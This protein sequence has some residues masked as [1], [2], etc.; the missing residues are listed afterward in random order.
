M[1]G[2]TILQYQI[3]EKFGEGGMGV[4]Y[5][6]RD[7]KLNRIVA[8][9]VLPPELVSDPGRKARF[10]QEARAAS[11]LNHPNIVTIH[12]IVSQDS[13][14]CI[15]ME[16]V[17]G[18]P[19]AQLIALKE[20]RIPDILKL[21]AQIAD[22]IAAAHT[23]GI[24]HRDLKPS[25]IMV[26]ES[27]LV[28]VLDFGLAKLISGPP[29]PAGATI[30]LPRTDPGMI[31]GT[32]G[33]MSPEQVRGQEL[34]R[35]SDIFNFGLILY[36]MLAGMRAFQGDTSADVAS[37]ILKESPPD[38]P[39]SVP[40][41]LRQIVAI[42][43]EKS[44]INRFES[45]RDIGF[46]LRALSTGTSI[47]GVVP[48][49]EAAAPK[50]RPWKWGS[51]LAWGA[52]AATA[53]VFTALYFLGRPEPLD[54]SAYKYTPFATEA[55]LETGGAWSPDGKSI[56]YLKNPGVRGQLFVRSL[57]SPIPTQ[58]ANDTT[59]I[60]VNPFWSPQGNRVYFIN[61]RKLWSV[62]VAGG[63]PLL[64]LSDVD[65]AAALSPEGNALAFWR[66][67][68]REGKRMSSLWISSPPGSPPRKY[69]PAPFESEGSGNPI[70]IRFAPD[71]AK[72]CLSEV[73]TNSVWLLDWPDGPKA[74]AR[75][76]FPG[77]VFSWAPAFDWMPNSRHLVMAINGELWL[78]D[79][80]TGK[81]RQATSSETGGLN[82]PSVSPDGQRIV[83]TVSND[84]YNIV[85]I[86]LDG[87]APRPYLAT[88]RDERSPS[89][90]LAGDRMAY[91]TKRSG[92]D[93]IWLR[94][95][96]G[97]WERPIVT[98]AD[99]PD[100]TDSAFFLMALSPDGGQVAFS[101]QDREGAKIWIA[102]ASGGKAM[103]AMPGITQWEIAPSFSPDGALFACVVF[104]DR[105]QIAVVRVGSPEPPYYH[106]DPSPSTA[107]I[108]S[109]DGRSI[110]YGSGEELILITPD[111]KITRRIPSP[112]R[113]SNQ[114]FVM[115]WSRDSSVIYMASSQSQMAQ[116]FAVEVNTGKATK[117]ADLGNDIEFSNDVGYSMSGSLSPDGKG[118]FTSDRVRKSDLWILEGFPQ[119]QRRRRR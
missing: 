64:A 1:V 80:K 12:D 105:G 117:L 35:R 116:L 61:D 7:T 5:R 74:K 15:V 85:E 30:T 19:L 114:N 97:D 70:F 47:T 96:S 86:P 53:V 90:S 111:G 10:V 78:G 43:L 4:V 51:R 118:F 94:S 54:L 59:G 3:L 6:A 49:E 81:L 102:S 39:E 112:M 82:N 20:N 34:D 99:F 27:G 87:S 113:P 71:G 28:K 41:A 79:T 67:E 107:P 72:I 98:Q 9:K 17:E 75:R 73:F 29:G 57:N 38:L 91:I 62:G 88:S 69:E 95:A 63:T 104:T 22:A 68:E 21:T 76:I 93:E 25:N 11:A 44:P 103:M 40:A 31:V 101:R 52:T 23:A 42:C 100:G 46:A 77:H 26:T 18:Q 32:P 55:D 60:S 119:P 110:A 8:I 36:E 16:F 89:W 84:D 13:G 2:S 106:K 58:L 109:P 24:I 48:K 50:D 65:S 14:E 45:A 115:V 92:K 37:A 66:T 56:A 83:Y 108:W 33:Y